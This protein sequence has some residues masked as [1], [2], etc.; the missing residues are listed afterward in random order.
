MVA[1]LLETRVSYLG[2]RDYTTTWREMR[3]LTIERTAQTPDQ[4]WIVQHPPVYTL[5]Q[6]GKQE[7]I[8]AAGSTPIVKTDR[9]GQVTWHGPGQ[10]VA[11]PL[12]DLRRWNITVRSLIFALEQAIISL[13]AVHG[14]ASH[15]RSDAPGVYVDGAKIAALGIR[16]KQGCSYHGVA[17]N[18]NND[19][20]PFSR[21]NPCGYADLTT[22]RLYNH[23]VSPSL[24]RLE[25]E[26]A[27]QLLAALERQTKVNL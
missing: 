5:G 20:E 2:L 6:A 10:I 18:I 4:L 21:I 9:G 23:G 14:I 22:T 1:A 26:L 24:Q 19:L 16:V 3:E 13:L 11:Y 27:I 7:H 8:L 17:V 25:V 15:R 12:L